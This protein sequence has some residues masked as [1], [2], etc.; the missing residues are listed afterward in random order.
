M[1]EGGYELYIDV[2]PGERRAALVDPQGRLERLRIDRDGRP[3][4]AETILQARVTAVDRQTGAAFLDLGP[5]GQGM[6]AKAAKLTEG[7][8]ITVQVTREGHGSKGAAVT[9]AWCLTERY[10]SWT[11]GRKGVSWARALG[12]GKARAELEQMLQA[13]LD[14]ADDGTL[15]DGL[16][17]RAQALSADEKALAGDLA[18]LA[19][20]RRA[21]Q[22]AA[23]GAK[24][25]TVLEAAPEFAR[26]AVR[27]APADTRVATDD[28]LLVSRLRD[29][30]EADWPDLAGA[31]AFSD[32]AKGALFDRAG[33]SDALEEALAREV[34]VPGG[35]RL[36]I[37]RTEA[38]TVIDVD[39]GR[40]VDGGG[41]KEEAVFRLNKRACE[42]AARQIRLRNLSGLIVIDCVTLR[43]KGRQRALVE[44]LRAAVKSDPVKTDV[45]GVTAGGLIEITRQR[46]GPGLAEIMRAPAGDLAPAPDAQAAAILR[47][48]LRLNG[49]GT[50]VAVASEAVSRAFEGP[51]A[52]A[53]ADCERRLGRPLE[54]RHGADSVPPTVTLE[55]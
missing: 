35:G 10:L 12:Q 41:L 14:A 18:R 24:P 9:R 50:P 43:A 55:R 30:A 13:A 40:S 54:I 17:V 36:I 39:S 26:L 42:E 28:R 51:L 22:D 20:R 1:S 46:T 53:K 5:A 27:D 25:P 31:I 29:R 4:F 48:A 3:A 52:A 32:P 15:A 2:S 33:V 6:L 47:A 11:E 38:M 37:D 49:P 34:A 21:V 44:S 23:T 7:A 19:A 8:A 45:L 16:A